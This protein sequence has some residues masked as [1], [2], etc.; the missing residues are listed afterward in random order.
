MVDGWS[1]ATGDVGGDGVDGVTNIEDGGGAEPASY[2]CCASHQLDS[3]SWRSTRC[4]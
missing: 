1:G 2:R 3:Q 4:I